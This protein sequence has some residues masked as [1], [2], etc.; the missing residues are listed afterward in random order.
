MERGNTKHSARRD[1]EMEH[2]V[3]GE[4][5][6]NP[7]SPRAEEWHQP[8][9][10]G[11]DQPDIDRIPDASPVGGTPEGMTEADVAGRNELA[12]HLRYTE[13]PADRERLLTV[14]TEMQ[15]PDRVIAE[16]SRLPDNQT[17]ENVTDVWEVLGHGRERG[18]A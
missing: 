11:E 4:L 5:Q 6:G 9:P 13:F 7:V 15:A 1:E 17:F 10:S 14:A 2:E 16:L 3:R 12:S 8:E 18:R